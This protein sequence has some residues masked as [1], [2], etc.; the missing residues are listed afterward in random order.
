MLW[1][2][3]EDT[4]RHWYQL[5]GVASQTLTGKF[6]DIKDAQERLLNPPDR[7]LTLEEVEKELDLED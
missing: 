7:Y 2:L 4:G 3:W 1:D 5:K 6:E